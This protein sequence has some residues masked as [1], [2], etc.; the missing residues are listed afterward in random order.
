MNV[1][2]THIGRVATGGSTTITAIKE[3][4]LI[5]V[6]G[7]AITISYGRCR[8]PTLGQQRRAIRKVVA[9]RSLVIRAR[10][11]AGE[12]SHQIRTETTVRTRARLT[13]VDVLTNGRSSFT[14]EAC[15]DLTSGATTIS[16][17]VISIIAGLNTIEDAIPAKIHDTRVLRSRV[18]IAATCP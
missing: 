6:R 9:G 12:G 18:V 13:L 7:V 17:Y 11:I 5:I 16:T 8:S 15:L 1:A 2:S 14:L 4:P 10:A 3:T